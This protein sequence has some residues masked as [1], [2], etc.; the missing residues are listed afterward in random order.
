M[1]VGFIFSGY[2]NQFVGMGKEFYDDSRVMQEYFEEAANCLDKNFVKLCFASSD[3]QLTQ[4]ENGYISLFLVSLSIAAILKERGITPSVVAGRDIG[5]YAAIASVGGISLPDAIYL[6]RKYAGL[7]EL[8]L[9]TRKFEAIRIKEVAS[10]DVAAACTACMN[11]N[12]LSAISVYESEAQCIVS[13]TA[14]AVACVKKALHKKKDGGVCESVSIGGGMHSQLM[15]EILKNMKMYLEKVDFKEVETPFV[16]S[17]TGQVLKEGDAVR[18][19]VMQQIHAPIQWKK[20][21]E[22]FAFC[23]TI[24]IVGPGKLL[25]EFVSNMYPDKLVIAA[26]TPTD[27]NIILEKYEKE[28]FIPMNEESFE[29]EGSVDRAARKL[30][31]NEEI[32]TTLEE[33]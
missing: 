20:T 24:V 9:E 10:E 25:Q 15:D 12:Q 6:L 33:E 16:A 3:A 2:G 11:G 4:L 26:I 13:G 31:E 14:D 23:E 19:A 30:A 5:E 32:D 18:A 8:F 28:L 29:I 21:L 7:Y 22:A 17:L 27:L 1:K